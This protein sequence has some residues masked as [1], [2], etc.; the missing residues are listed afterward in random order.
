MNRRQHLKT[1][2]L[3]TMSAALP[4]ATGHPI[5]LHVDL[6]VD[7]ARESELLAVFKDHFQPA[8]SHQPGFVEV[9]LLKLVAAMSGPPLL[10]NYNYRLVIS[11]ETEDQRK[12]WVAT[13]EHQKIWPAV[14]A[15][16]KGA[17]FSSA[18]YEIA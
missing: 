6:E 5:Q 8:I 13:P 12:A 16:L 18:L 10:G 15:N 3:G 1:L 9:R 2:A 17:K 14:A 4:A 7:P 11:F